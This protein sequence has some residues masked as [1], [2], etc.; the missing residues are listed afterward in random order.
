MGGGGTIFKKIR[1]LDNFK[2]KLSNIT[3]QQFNLKTETLIWCFIG[4]S[5]A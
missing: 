4:L 5:P 2:Y 1:G 3:N